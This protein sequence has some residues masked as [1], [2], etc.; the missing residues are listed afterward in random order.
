[1][2]PGTAGG[3]RSAYAVFFALALSACAEEMIRPGT[4]LVATDRVIAPYESRE[5]CAK[6]VPGDRLDYYFKSQMPLAFNIHYHEGKIVIMPV[7]R[8]DTTADSGIFRPRLAQEYC[9]MWEAGRNGA[10]LDYRITLTPG[11][12]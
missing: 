6:L 1:M 2:I 10:I 8:D 9:L 7:T 3:D 4:P 5:E 12:R 11:T